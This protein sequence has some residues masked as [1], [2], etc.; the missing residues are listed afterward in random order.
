M[1]INSTTI[2]YNSGNKV[3]WRFADPLFKS[4]EIR[5]FD[6]VF[7]ITILT[8]SSRI[9]LAEIHCSGIKVNGKLNQSSLP[10][11]NLEYFQKRE[12]SLIS[13]FTIRCKFHVEFDNRTQ[14]VS[15]I[16]I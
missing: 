13:Q 4:I 5:Q 11:P 3:I 14:I 8:Y 12:D 10:L 15:F 7:N 9:K 6:D 2:K 1:A 16:K